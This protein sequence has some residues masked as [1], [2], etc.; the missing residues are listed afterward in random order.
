MFRKEFSAPNNVYQIRSC[1]CPLISLRDGACVVTGG[2]DLK[3]RIYDVLRD[4]RPCVNELMGH[5][6]PVLDVCWNHE[7]SLLGSCDAGGNV[8]LWKRVKNIQNNE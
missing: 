4:E 5:S 7:E 3:I 1:F 2:E 6:F 8:I